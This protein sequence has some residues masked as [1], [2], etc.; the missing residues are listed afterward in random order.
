MDVEILVS[1]I[2]YSIP[3]YLT[4]FTL[5]AVRAVKGPTIPDAVLAIDSMSYDLAAFIAV[6][7]VL[8][9]SSV[10]IA[11]AIVLALWVFAL[12]IYVAKYL[13]SREMGE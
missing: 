5:Y 2:L 3:V 12:D 4:A 1:A 9:K 13:E 6:L 7:S 11:V 10:L 8:F